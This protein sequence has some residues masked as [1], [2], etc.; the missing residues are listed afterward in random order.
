MLHFSFFLFIVLLLQW[1]R[2]CSAHFHVWL[3]Q[4]QQ[5]KEQKDISLR[6][7]IST[8]SLFVRTIKHDCTMNNWKGVIKRKKM[9]K[10]QGKRHSS[11]QECLIL[12]TASY[13][14]ECKTFVNSQ[15]AF[16]H[17]S[18]KAGILSACNRL[19]ICNTFHVG[20]FL[21]ASVVVC[22]LLC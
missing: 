7:F 18:M 4:K 11:Q 2:S 1:I 17:Q 9:V 21:W 12:S 8:A 3:E 14:I 19:K 20:I 6:H 15:W 16:Y 10:L 13:Q 5:N 22:V